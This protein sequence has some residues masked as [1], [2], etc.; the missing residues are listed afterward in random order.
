MITVQNTFQTEKKKSS[1]FTKTLLVDYLIERLLGKDNL[2]SFLS[3]IFSNVPISLLFA[4][5]EYGNTCWAHVYFFCW[6]IAIAFSITL[7]IF[8]FRLTIKVIE[9]DKE[10][11]QG[12]GSEG[13]ALIKE[14]QL[15]HNRNYLKKII[16]GFGI[17]ATL[18][19]C[20]V[21]MMSIIVILGLR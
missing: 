16:I 7:T 1:Q 9:I 2:L 21:A 17:F 19:I 8:S 5:V 15:Q 3:G 12:M 6:L 13:K 11:H 14:L 20:V 18:T 4:A 10:I